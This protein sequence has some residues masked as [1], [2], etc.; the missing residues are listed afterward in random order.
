MRTHSNSKT[1][2]EMSPK[3]IFG[4]KNV[5][6]RIAQYAFAFN[7]VKTTP[8][9]DVICRRPGRAPGNGVVAN[10]K[11]EEDEALALVPLPMLASQLLSLNQALIP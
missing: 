11:G 1:E 7:C 3:R 4:S 6:Q 8:Q 2:V 9:S 5:V 10:T